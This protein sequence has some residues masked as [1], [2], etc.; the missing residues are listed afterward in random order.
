MKKVMITLDYEDDYN[1]ENFVEWCDKVLEFLLE[2]GENI[3]IT[4]L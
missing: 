1:D 2:Y 3:D 4:E